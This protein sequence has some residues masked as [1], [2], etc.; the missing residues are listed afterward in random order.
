MELFL[1]IR[2]TQ[3]KKV[4]KSSREGLDWLKHNIY[5]QVKYQGKIHTE[6]Q[7]DT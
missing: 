5:L 1:K 2:T 4:R 6:Q 3:E 7:T